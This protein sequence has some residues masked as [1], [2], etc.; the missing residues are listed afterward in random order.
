MVNI[1][2][3]DFN[4]ILDS[5]KKWLAQNKQE[6]SCIVIR[7]WLKGLSLTKYYSNV[8]WLRKEIE[9]TCNI[10]GHSY[11]LSAEEME[12]IL[13][14]FRE[15]IKQFSII[16]NDHEIVKNKKIHNDTLPIHHC[17]NTTTY[18]TK[19]RID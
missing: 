14:H 19:T 10:T 15:V 4:K 9:S 1:S 6:L 3:E 8:T 13:N 7:N 12:Q 18:N 5:A 17:K 16:K 2:S 11:D